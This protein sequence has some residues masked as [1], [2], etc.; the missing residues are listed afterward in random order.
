MTESK[1]ILG[2]VTSKKMVY[3]IHGTN[4]KYI[5]GFIT[6]EGGALFICGFITFA[7]EGLFYFRVF[8]I[9]R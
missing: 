4:T 3:Y 8:Y 2:S 6:F 5:F 1:R 9:I 7:G